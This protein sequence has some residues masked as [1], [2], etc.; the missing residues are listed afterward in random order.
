MGSDKPFL[1]RFLDRN[2]LD[3]FLDSDG[4]GEVLGDPKRSQVKRIGLWLGRL[5]LV[6][7]F[8]VRQAVGGTLGVGLDR[9]SWWTLG[10]IQAKREPVLDFLARRRVGVRV[11]LAIL[12]LAIIAH[13]VCP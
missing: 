3:E 2:R 13:E 4:R 9:R 8:A 7:S 10:R 11:C 1:R 5:G 6:R 12:S